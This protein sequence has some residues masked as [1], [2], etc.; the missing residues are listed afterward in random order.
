MEILLQF[1][2]ATTTAAAAAVAAFFSSCALARRI[3]SHLMNAPAQQA[4]RLLSIAGDSRLLA[5]CEWARIKGKKDAD[6]VREREKK[7][8]NKSLLLSRH[9]TQ[10]SQPLSSHP[11]VSLNALWAL[12]CLLALSLAA[13]E[14]RLDYLFYFL[15][16]FPLCVSQRFSKCLYVCARFHRRLHII[17]QTKSRALLSAQSPERTLLLLLYFCSLTARASFC[18]HLCVCDRATLSEPNTLHY[19]ISFSLILETF[20]SSITIKSPSSSSSFW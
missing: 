17:C 1:S 3:E 16:L 9:L 2:R 18:V 13:S 4:L 19:S 20:S 6:W 5:A 7:R 8:S 12:T 14:K 10:S 11:L 15:P